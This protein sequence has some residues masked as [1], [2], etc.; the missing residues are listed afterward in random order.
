MLAAGLFAEVGVLLGAAGG[1]GVDSKVS[2]F[3]QV[4]ACAG[5]DLYGTSCLKIGFGRM[6]SAKGVLNSSVIDVTSSFPFGM[7]RK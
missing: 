2:A 1:G 4:I 5:I 3:E 6:R 7:P